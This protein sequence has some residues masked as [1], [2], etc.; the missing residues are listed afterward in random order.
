MDEFQVSSKTLPVLFDLIAATKCVLLKLATLWSWAYGSAYGRSN[1]FVL[2]VIAD[3]APIALTPD[4]GAP[5]VRYADG[6]MD[7]HIGY[8]VTVRE[9]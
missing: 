9:G 5:V 6:V 2:T 8:Y 3:H 1:I 4:Y 7:L